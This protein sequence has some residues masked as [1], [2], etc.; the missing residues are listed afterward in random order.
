[1]NDPSCG[2]IVSDTGGGDGESTQPC[3]EGTIT[4]R[5]GTLAGGTGSAA[6]NR[7]ALSNPNP[8]TASCSQDFL[9]VLSLGMA[10]AGR[11]LILSIGIFG[12]PA[13]LN[14]AQL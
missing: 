8:N 11:G 13:L 14:P 10:V 9:I 1:M 6:F 5:Q 7:P 3:G 2:T 12:A 4:G